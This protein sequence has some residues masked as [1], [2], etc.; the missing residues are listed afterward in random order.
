MTRLD[1]AVRAH[2]CEPSAARSLSLPLLCAAATDDT[3]I[4]V[5]DD[6]EADVAGIDVL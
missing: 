6:D 1:G 3:I 2:Q 5:L 4:A